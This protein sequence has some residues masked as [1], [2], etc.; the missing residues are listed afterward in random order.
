M[1]GDKILDEK[2]LTKFYSKLQIEESVLDM[3]EV[4][5]MEP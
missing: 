1:K 2:M 4:T 5:N 3:Y